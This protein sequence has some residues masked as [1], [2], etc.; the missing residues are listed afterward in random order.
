MIRGIPQD[1]AYG[2][3]APFRP[4]REIGRG[5]HG[6]V[7]LA[8]GPNGRVAL[9][10]C[11]RPDDPGA[12]DNWERERRGWSLLAS[13]PPHRSL[14]RVFAKGGTPDGAAF[15][16]A[17]ELADAEEGGDAANLD[18]YRPKT[19]A[20]V[21]AAEVAL[22]LR[23]CVD[24][25]LRLASGLEHLQR[26]HL[27][28][29]DIKP[30]NILYIRG[31]PVIADAGLVVDAREAASL[32]GTPG[33]VPPENHGSPQ[34]DVF[35]LGKT[36]WRI[37]TGRSPDETSFAPCAEADTAEPLFGEF[38]GI[39]LRAMS[40]SPAKRFRSAKALRKALVRLRRK[41]VQSRIDGIVHSV[42]TA[43][44]IAF[45]LL[46]AL[47]YARGIRIF[48][49]YKLPTIGGGGD[50]LDPLREGIRS[51]KIHILTDGEAEAIGRDAQRIVDEAASNLQES[52]GELQ[53]P[54]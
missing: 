54:E 6:A 23:D 51:G 26:H 16:V 13:I 10:V 4:V 15:W 37:A 3:F 11:R 8:E 45:L 31:N 46:L 34:G 9:K 14:V 30:G 53:T 42:L 49:D 29:R 52:I 7:F 33:Y 43:L 1:F 20:S 35:S 21:A 38:M 24:I 36:L 41:K 27:L 12:L 22:P 32:V 50:P 48:P 5:A 40:P 25:G 17:M 39:L 2:A 28:H 18:A 44:G 19:L 47:A